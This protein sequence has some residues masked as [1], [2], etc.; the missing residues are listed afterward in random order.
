MSD[1]SFHEALR[2]TYTGNKGP[3]EVVAAGRKRKDGC[4]LEVRSEGQLPVDT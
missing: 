4:H 3:A 1:G 2:V